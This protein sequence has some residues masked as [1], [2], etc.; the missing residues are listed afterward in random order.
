VYTVRYEEVVFVLH[1]FQKKS[2]SGIAVPKVDKAVI[3][4]GLKAAAERIKEIRDGK[5]SR[6]DAAS[7]RRAHGHLEAEGVCLLKGDFANVSE[8]T[9]MDCLN[10]LAMTSRSG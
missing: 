2:E 4:T 8:R 3:E 5:A 9:L 7:G 6:A 1:C 10:R